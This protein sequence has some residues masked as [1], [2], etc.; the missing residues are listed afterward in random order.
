[1][2]RLDINSDGFN[3]TASQ[4][5]YYIDFAEWINTDDCIYYFPLSTL[6]DNGFATI[7]EQTCVVPFDNIYRLEQ[8]DR[9][10]L[11]IPKYYDK[12]MRLRGE[13][14]L[15]LSDFNYQLEYLTPKG[16]LIEHNR[17]KNILITSNQKYLL[18]KTQYRLAELVSRYNQANSN[19]KTFDYNLRCFSEI[20]SLAI[21]SGCELDSYLLNENVF[22]PEKIA[23]HIDVDDEGIKVEPSIDIEEKE[24]FT[25]TFGRMRKVLSV[26]PLSKDN[27]ERVRVVL[28]HQ[29]KEDLETLKKSGS[30]YKSKEFVKDLIEHPTAYFDPN[31]F[32]L[33]NLYSDRVI[34]IGVYKPKFYP[35]ICPYK[36]EWI[37]VAK[38]TTS[39]GG[40]NYLA[41]KTREDLEELYVA[42]NKTKE[43]KKEIVNFRNNLIALEDAELLAKK[44]EKQLENQTSPNGDSPVVK[45]TPP[46]LLIEE[47][48][49]NDIYIWDNIRLRHEDKY[50]LYPNPNLQKNITLKT[51]QEEG[52]AW[53][54][55]LYMNNAG[56]CLLAD[57]MGLGKTL[58]ILYFI[59]WHSHEHQQHKPYLIVVPPSLLE[60]WE[61]E[62]K[63]FFTSP[64]LKVKRLSTKEVPRQF[65]E[66]EIE[67][68]QNMDII[69]TNYETLRNAQLN[70]C[71]VEF[72]IVVLDEAQKVKTPGTLVTNAVKAL[73][74]NFRIAM[75]GT[76]V[77]NT[78]VDLWCIMD[79][80]VPGLLGNAK[81]F[82]AKYQTPLKN[83]DTDIEEL[84]NEIHKR[85][86]IYLM[87]RMKKD[88]AKDLPV[89]YELK[90]EIEMPAKQEEIYES[91]VDEFNNEEDGN[92]LETI[93]RI[94]EISEHPYLYEHTIGQHD[95]PEL[96]NVSARLRATIP[97]LD[98]IRDKN[99][100]AILFAERKE[101]QRMLQRISFER[102]GI[103]AKI[104]N[105]DMPA[106]VSNSKSSNKVSRQKAIDEFQKKE[107]FNI[108][109]MSPIAAGMGLNVT[110]A[111]HVIHYSRH[112]N[113][114]KES[115]ATDRVYR[116]G[117][118]KD[119]YIYYPMAV[120][121]SFKSFD[122]T[123]D[124]LLNNKT[125][126]ANSTIFPTERIE[127]KQ[128]E[129][130]NTL[131]GN[132]K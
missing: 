32:D 54:Q 19:E 6:K 67:K 95:V 83:E 5:E 11:G 128:A 75:T 114:A 129:I 115:Q 63:R 38:I 90:Q 111:N 71:A 30:K 126:L 2:L 119:V 88:V 7:Q 62:Y 4:G 117:Q 121:R 12:A 86:G 127:V 94:R 66:K 101:T 130:G 59:D 3:F 23:I 61:N 107:G 20:K 89:K 13:G 96:I 104:I 60:N 33:S 35:F 49:E 91:V 52:V 40:T 57:D 18:P 26:Y 17:L 21:E 28:N 85:L 39:T 110:A 131:F 1:M 45:E 16:E 125:A 118:T 31:V 69:L 82:A 84:G 112:W 99:E 41:I 70:F 53:L 14:T 47:N 76:P 73:K 109:I 98:T 55:H 37:V 120:S 25:S 79:F 92:M 29:Q 65:D 81:E 43:H 113:P 78:L 9:D 105:G 10:L 102:Y 122:K 80:C 56:G 15:N 44:A 58:Q 108:I 22:V 27:G 97:F 123:L 36:T 42:I 68:M 116:I 103:E 51:H 132:V 46:V 34:D 48:I 74:S 93:L 50:T 124:E 100:K 64:H 87:R 72:D 24:K 77:E 106:N 8:T